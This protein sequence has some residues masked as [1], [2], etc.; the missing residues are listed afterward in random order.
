MTIRLSIHNLL[1]RIVTSSE[2]DRKLYF[3][4]DLSSAKKSS[5]DFL[6]DRA[7]TLK[8]L[9][10]HRSPLMP[11]GAL[12]F[13]L[14]YASSEGEPLP[15][16]FASVRTQFADLAQTKLKILADHVYEFRNTY[17]AH[18]KAELQNTD[19]ARAAIA[20]WIE[21]LAVLERCVGGT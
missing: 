2:P 18:T 12:T 16:I 4:P 7:R 14:D 20:T 10:V 15:G 11:T 3:E 1:P 17:I 5:V 13:C 21:T 19:E 8:R 9:L 6:T